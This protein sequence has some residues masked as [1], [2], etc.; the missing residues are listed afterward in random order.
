M[1][2]RCRHRQCQTL[3]PLRNL[4]F[5]RGPRRQLDNLLHRSYL[6]RNLVRHRLP[7]PYHLSLLKPDH[8]LLTM[9]LPDSSIFQVKGRQ[10]SAFQ[11][12]LVPRTGLQP[13][14]HLLILS[15]RHSL[16]RKNVLPTTP[17][18][19]TS[20]SPSPN[21]SAASSFAV[22]LQHRN[23]SRYL[24]HHHRHRHHRYQTEP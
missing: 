22:K 11:R 7:A 18:Q 24:R 14:F 8:R 2:D 21:E 19:D 9:T 5:S 12:H 10:P 3:W 6:V 16:L 4:I 20:G 23:L 17:N 13:I 1:I 15:L